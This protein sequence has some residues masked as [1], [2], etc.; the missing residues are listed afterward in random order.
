MYGW[1]QGVLDFYFGYLPLPADEALE[2]RKQLMD[3]GTFTP[4]G[5]KTL[6]AQVDEVPAERILEMYDFVLNKMD[7]ITESY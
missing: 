4:S 2:L 3:F 7:E 5:E 1:P 6:K